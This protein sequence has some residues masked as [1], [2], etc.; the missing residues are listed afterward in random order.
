[1]A[2]LHPLQ[3]LD[4][5]QRLP[6]PQLRQ[7]DFPL[8]RRTPRH[9]ELLSRRTQP[10]RRM[11]RPPSVAG[12]LFPHARRRP[13]EPQRVV[14]RLETRTSGHHRELPRRRPHRKRRARTH[15]AQRRGLGAHA[16]RGTTGREGGLHLQPHGLRLP[17]RPGRRHHGRHDAR[18]QPRAYAL[19]R[20]G[21]RIPARR[22]V[23]LHGRSHG[24]PALRAQHRPQRGIGG[25]HP[26]HRLRQGTHRALA[27]GHGTLAPRRS[28]RPG[29]HAARGALRR[30]VVARGPGPFRRLGG[31]GA[32]QRDVQGLRI[33]QLPLSHAHR[34]LLPPGRQRGAA[35]RARIHLRCGRVVRRGAP[36]LLEPHG[37]SHGIRF[38][39]RRL[40]HP[41][42]DGRQQEF[43]AA[44][45][46]EEGA[47]L[48]R[49]NES[50]A[51]RAPGRRVA[52][53]ARRHLRVDALDQPQRT[54]RRQRPV[55]RQTAGLRARILVGRHRTARLAHVA[56][57][58]QVE[59][60]LVTLHHVQQ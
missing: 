20:P 35:A 24:P 16:H 41:P 23:V 44:P 48:R 7:E 45:Q 11:A 59:L 30:P 47:Q 54:A 2:D 21:G 57:D 50:L 34:P 58:L 49:G 18:A 42:A 15:A 6:L 1:M 55:G 9:G 22:T 31:V 38:V 26:R 8:R 60:L 39:H 40:D 10:Q 56:P 3:L 36:R 43:L 5:A 51:R 28:L 29:L 25:Q 27:H 17:Q 33:A 53:G 13:L 32:G 14:P 37:R 4:L 19:R 52:P 12:V 46:H